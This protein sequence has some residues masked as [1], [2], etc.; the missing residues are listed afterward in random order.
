MNKLKYIFLVFAMSALSACDITEV[1]IDP[2]RQTDVDLSL[3]LPQ[4]LSQAAYNQSANQARVPGIILQQFQGFD[5]QQL[6]FTDYVIG[7]DTYNN[8]WTLGLYSGVLRSAQNVIDKAQESGDSY[9]EGIAKIIMA[10]S[11]G[12]ATMFFGDIPF[13]EALKGQENLKPVYDPQE[14][15][16]N[17]I[18]AMLDDAINLLSAQQGVAP[19]SDDL[20][21]GGDAALWIKTAHALKARYLMQASKRQSGN[22]GKALAEIGNALASIEEQPWFPFQGNQIANNP[23]AKFGIE[24]PNT[25]IIDERFANAMGE[26]NDPRQVKY[27]ED[28]GE[29][30]SFFN[31]SNPDLVWTQNNSQIPLISYVE[32]KFLEAEALQRNGAPASEVQAALADAIAASIAQVGLDPAEH[33]AFIDAQSDLSG[34]SGEGIIQRIIEEAY[35]AYYGFAFQ[36]VWNNYRR[37]GYPDLTPSPQG[38]NGLNPSGGIPRRFLYPVSEVQTN[39]ENLNAAKAAQGGALMDQ[40]VWA[41][42]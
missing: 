40:D 11:Y 29:Q 5:A 3:I 19:G 37:T 24:R 10:E 41:F 39:S 38:A 35:Y 12:M 31:A 16:I 20:I 26:R 33:Q 6:G 30:W 1:N 23:L 17:G 18:L 21:Y 15:V 25:M 42:E 32:V 8:Y 9:Y 13:S 27:M 28:A 4:V 34:L 22:A 36:Q 14:Q 7:E 2:T